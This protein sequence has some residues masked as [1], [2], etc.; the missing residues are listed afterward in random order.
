VLKSMINTIQNVILC[1]K[2]CKIN[3]VDLITKDA[4]FKV[5]YIC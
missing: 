5:I 2:K 3:K 4:V 1:Y